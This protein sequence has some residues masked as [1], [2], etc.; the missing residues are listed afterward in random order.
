MRVRFAPTPRESPEPWIFEPH[1]DYILPCE[2]KR[3]KGDIMLNPILKKTPSVK[4]ATK[5][6]RPLSVPLL[7]NLCMDV[8]I[9][10]VCVFIFM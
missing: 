3:Q 6:R 5:R 9:R 4:Y 10:N 1:L 2:V 8:L 7:R